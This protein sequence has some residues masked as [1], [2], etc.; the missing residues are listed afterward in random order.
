MNE[1]RP[2][3]IRAHENGKGVREIAR[4]LDIE[5]STVSRTIKRFEETGS[6]ERILSHEPTM[7][8]ATMS[9]LF[10]R[11]GPRTQSNR[12]PKF[13]SCELPWFHIGRY[14]LAQQRRWM[15]AKLT[16]FKPS[17][18]LCVEHSRRKS[19][20]ET[21]PECGILEASFEEGM[22]RNHLGNFDQDR[23]QLS[24]ATEG[25][26]G[27]KRRTFWINLVVVIVICCILN[28]FV[29]KMLLKRKKIKRCSFISHPVYDNLGSSVYGWET[30]WST[31]I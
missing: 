13:H 27:C 6:N 7:L 14:P 23:G 21:P 29:E 11:T 31:L 24:E 8:L 1:L 10:N 15:S 17:G 20:C 9:G 16:R 25:L 30:C 19:V 18:L 22:E 28:K 12:D 4:F 5:P 2:A 26:H 3:I